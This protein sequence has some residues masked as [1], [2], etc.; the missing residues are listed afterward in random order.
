M[1]Q[2]AVAVIVALEGRGVLDA[3]PS[4]GMTRSGHKKNPPKALPPADH[5]YR[6]FGVLRLHIRLHRFCRDRQRA[7]ARAAGVED[8]VAK[9]GKRFEATLEEVLPSVPSGKNRNRNNP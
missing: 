7:E 4:R 9:R 5:S 8:G 2:Y 6:R 1:I 3:P